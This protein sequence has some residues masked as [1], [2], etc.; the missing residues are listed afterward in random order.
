MLIIEKSRDTFCSVYTTNPYTMCFC[1][2]I[3]S[4]WNYNLVRTQLAGTKI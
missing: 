4:R 1:V 2:K 3:N